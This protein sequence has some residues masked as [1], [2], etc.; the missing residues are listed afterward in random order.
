M[1]DKDLLS[2]QEARALVRAARKAQAEFCQLGQE[3]VDEVVK[4]VSEATAACA[5]ELASEAVEET[6]FGKSHDKRIKNLLA[7]QKVYD[8]IRDMKTIGL[9]RDDTER[10]VMEIA[11]PVGVIAGIV[12]S[13]NPTSTT[14]YKSLIALKAGNAIVFTP[15][16]SA[17]KCIGH[18][19]EI[20][21]EALTRCGVS[22][23]LVSSISVPTMEGSAE[24][25]RICDL[26]LATGGPG[27]VKAAYS[28]GTP[29]LGV[30]AGNV[31]A[32]IER[33]AKIQDAVAKIMSSK[34][35]DNGT[36]CASE[37]SIVTERC[38]ADK[39]RNALV[40]QGGYF[41]EGEKLEKVK[42]IMERGNGSMNP[43]IVG[44]DALTI[45]RLAGIE[46]PANTRL[47]ISDEPGIGPKYPFSKEKLTALLGFYVVEDWHEAC[48]VCTR[49]LENCGIGHS[50]AI[51]SQNKEIIKEFGL[52]KPVSRILVNT[53]STQGAVGI[54]TSL[55]PSFTLGCGTVGGSATSDNVTPLNLINIRRV[56]YGLESGDIWQPRNCQ[57]HAGRVCTGST[58]QPCYGTAAPQPKTDNLDIS[59]ITAMIVE[60]LKKSMQN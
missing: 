17:T 8:S 12:P 5:S 38:I 22:S 43:K 54:S 37:Q 14:I 1:I 35:F 60:E 59:A 16:P 44:R 29:A 56:A 34:T 42:R 32:F 18:T 33:S 9:L 21:K 15:H 13:T 36:I 50:L 39:V 11:V 10:R 7:S 4:A 46:V 30:G 45:A 51:H 26:I 27:M 47:L 55:F 52:K 20:I 6:G 57:P 58:L 53:P 23:D 49:L 3:K 25:M 40:A 19:V 48:E 31:P 41:L 2:M 28:S 24:L